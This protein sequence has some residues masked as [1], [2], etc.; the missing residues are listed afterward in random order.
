MF[1][2]PFAVVYFWYLN[3][4]LGTETIELHRGFFVS[5]SLAAI[6]QIFATACLV[7]AITIK[8]FAVGTALIK[9]EALLTAVI[10][11]VFFSATLSLLG[12][13]AVVVGVIGVLV[14]S[15]WKITLQD[16]AD[17]ASIKYGLGAG[18][19]FALASLWLR[20]ASLT[21]DIPRLLSAATTLVYM[22]A[23]QTVICFAWIV[24]LEP[25]QFA[26]IRQNLRAST[27]IGFTSVA[28]SIGWFTA[29]SLQEAALVKTLGQVEF[30]VT[31][32]ITYW[33]FGESIT[34]REYAGMGLVVISVFLLLQAS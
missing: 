4:N 2:L 29:M 20:E 13:L 17:N 16:L 12:Y 11:A 14:A 8:N 10:G 32:L 15:H 25:K 22:V 23:L 7:N 9:S 28:G 3:V 33:Y 19:G 5:A 31:L 34:R 24:L 18:L 21:L 1:G 30:M 6:S 26:L 27:F